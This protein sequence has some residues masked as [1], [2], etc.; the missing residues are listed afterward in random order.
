MS[1]KEE[2]FTYVVARKW[3]ADDPDDKPMCIYTFH[4]ETQRGTMKSAKAFLKYVTSQKDDKD[5]PPYSIYKVN[6]EKVGK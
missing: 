4:T 1:K 6:Y 2:I 5:A 3:K